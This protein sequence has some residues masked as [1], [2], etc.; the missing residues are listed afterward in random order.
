MSILHEYEAQSGQKINKKK[1]A[2]YLHESA[3]TAERQLVEEC[4]GISIGKFPF[5]YLGC[6]ITHSRKRKEHYAKLIKKVKA[7]LQS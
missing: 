4:T 3:G 1:S 2:C 7:K 6:P 5:K